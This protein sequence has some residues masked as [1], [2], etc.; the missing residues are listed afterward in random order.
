M[1]KFFLTPNN[2]IVERHLTRLWTH[3]AMLYIF[4]S[5]FNHL[6]VCNCV[7]ENFNHIR[8]RFILL[9]RNKSNKLSHIRHKIP[10]TFKQNKCIQTLPVQSQ[11]RLQVM[12]KLTFYW[13]ICKNLAAINQQRFKVS[14]GNLVL[15]FTAY[16]KLNSLFLVSF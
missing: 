8:S 14:Q 11:A 12:P 1:A 6:N 10:K 16:P 13:I 9:F 5:F 3:F 4:L 15:E 7:S 2:R